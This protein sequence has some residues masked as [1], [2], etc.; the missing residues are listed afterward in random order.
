MFARSSV[1]DSSE[2][3]LN[4]YALRSWVGLLK[5]NYEETMRA[6]RLIAFT[7]DAVLIGVPATGVALVL[8]G[9]N[10]TDAVIVGLGGGVVVAVLFQLQRKPTAGLFLAA[11]LLRR[12]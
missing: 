1:R 2:I 7:V 9:G 8:W 3:K 11:R 12:R 4:P 5:G 10:I 6:Q